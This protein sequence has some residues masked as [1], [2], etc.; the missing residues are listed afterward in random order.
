MI[1]SFLILILR[2]LKQLK[3]LQ[4]R[5][6]IDIKVRD[7]VMFGTIG[8]VHSSIIKWNKSTILQCVYRL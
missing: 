1:L 6:K 8:I 3:L 5:V 2:P 4:E 7:S